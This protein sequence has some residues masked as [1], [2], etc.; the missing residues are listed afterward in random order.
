M[1]VSSREGWGK[2]VIPRLAKD[3]HNEMPEVKGFSERNIGRMVAF[4]RAYSG[5]SLNFDTGCGKI[6]FIREKCHSSWHKRTLRQ[7]CNS[8]LQKSHGGTISC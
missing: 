2:A 6:G 5:S 8:L 1:N 4:Y 3:I 7:F